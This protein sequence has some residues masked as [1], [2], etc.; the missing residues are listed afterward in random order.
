MYHWVASFFNWLATM[1]GIHDGRMSAS[2]SLNSHGQGTKK[3]RQYLTTMVL[4]LFTSVVAVTSWHSRQT[5]VV[6]K[7]VRLA[8]WKIEGISDY[9][10][11][12]TADKKKNIKRDPS[13]FGDHI[14]E[15]ND[16]Y[17]NFDDP[18]NE[19]SDNDEALFNNQRRFQIRLHSISRTR[20]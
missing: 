11:K 2:S 8:K 17:Q 20:K 15:Q 7:V 5:Q 9:I 1:M 4:I 18:R 12:Y 10:H 13:L 6:S 16:Q 14:K 3:P 19:F